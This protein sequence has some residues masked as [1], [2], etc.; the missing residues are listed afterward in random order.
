MLSVLDMIARRAARLAVCQ[1]ASRCAAGLPVRQELVLRGC[2]QSLTAM[3]PAHL[4][5]KR[6]QGSKPKPRARPMRGGSY[7]DALVPRPDAARGA[8]HSES[9]SMPAPAK[10]R[11]SLLSRGQRLRRPRRETLSR[12]FFSGG[13]RQRWVIP[14]RGF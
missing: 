7:V 9:W 2:V 4:L 8:Q 5:L 13:C 1:D 3:V 6:D 14:L 12:A 10:V 11:L